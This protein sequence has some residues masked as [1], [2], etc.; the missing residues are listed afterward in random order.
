MNSISANQRSIW[1]MGLLWTLLLAA[2]LFLNILQ[3]DREVLRIARIQA[4]A[5]IDKDIELRL[6]A[7]SHGGVYVRT[8]PETQPNPYLDVA[9]RDVVTTDGLRLTLMNPAYI[10]R[11]VHSRFTEKYG[12]Y[13]HMTAL[14]LKNPA[15]APDAWERKALEGFDAGNLS[16]VSTV[17]SLAGKS[18][19]RLMKPL[20]ME[21]SCQTCHAW[22]RIPVGGVR[23]GINASVPLEPLREGE[24]TLVLYIG[25]SHGVMWLIGILAIGGVSRRVS[26]MRVA[27][28]IAEARNRELYEQATHD[29]LTGLFNRRY[30]E[31]ALTRQIHRA[32][33]VDAPLSL[34]MID[35]DHFKRFNDEHG[36]DAGDEVLRQ[37]GRSIRENVRTSD[38]VCRYG[39]EELAVIIPGAG[40]KEAFLRMDKLREA[41][42]A[43]PLSNRDGEA[44]PPVTVS[45]GVAELAEDSDDSSELLKR[46]DLACT[47]PKRRDATGW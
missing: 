5:F 36:H 23:G 38:I 44:L 46:A 15:N 47:A 45:I 32:H 2:S 29:A 6:W 24:G 34:V 40:A 13:G 9:Q 17:Y 31:E 43:V 39:G 25:L 30:M 26:R 21:E 1:S 14:K 10:T 22:T 12:V 18:Y 42:S 41:V 11:E 37:V 35:I 28:D 3:Q 16:D 7:S 8:G 20:L 4:Q 33:R 27:H 19:L